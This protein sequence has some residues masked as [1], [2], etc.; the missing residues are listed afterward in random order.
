MG[1]R[2]E[3]RP[4]RPWRHI[5]T[6]ILGSIPTISDL[7]VFFLLE[8]AGVLGYEVA[9]TPSHDELEQLWSDIDDYLATS[10]GRWDAD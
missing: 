7:G 5:W 8:P 1:D 9:G 10:A 6:G 4:K 2:H 3:R